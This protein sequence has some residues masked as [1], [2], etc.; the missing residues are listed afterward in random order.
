MGILSM[1]WGKWM[2]ENKRQ[3]G[4]NLYTHNGKRSVEFD[5]YA[6]MGGV[7]SSYNGCLIAKAHDF[8]S[9]FILAHELAHSFDINH[10][11]AEGCSTEFLLSSTIGTGQIK[12]SQCTLRAFRNFVHRLDRSDTNCLR[13]SSRKPPISNLRISHKKELPGRIFTADHQCEIRQG[14]GH[15]LFTGVMADGRR[16]SE[17]N[18]C[19]TLPCHDR[20]PS[21]YITLNHPAL[22]GTVCAKSKHCHNSPRLLWTSWSNW[23][24]C[25]SNFDKQAPSKCMKTRTRKCVSSDNPPK[26]IW[27]CIGHD[28]EKRS[29]LMKYCIY[30]ANKT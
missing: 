23:S 6:R 12:F 8:T 4:Q 26:E 24:R 1:I 13:R 15:S 18:L 27:G 17:D 7:C 21:S 3:S 9:S 5:G 16:H 30:S 2:I 19:Q 11:E 25:R 10:D 20:R 29:C 14:K 28:A 22:E